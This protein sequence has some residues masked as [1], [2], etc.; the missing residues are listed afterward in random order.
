MLPVVRDLFEPAVDLAATGR[1]PAGAITGVHSQYIIDLLPKKIGI[2]CWLM[3][4]SAIQQE[5]PLWVHS[6]NRLRQPSV[7]L[8]AGIVRVRFRIG[9][10]RNDAYNK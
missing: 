1:K 4:T 3:Q 5:N 10:I 8:K 7:S 6:S 9:L 2:W